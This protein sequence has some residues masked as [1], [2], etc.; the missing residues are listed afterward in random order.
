MRVQGHKG[1][2][3]YKGTRDARVARAQ[4]CEG[5]KSASHLVNFHCLIIVITRALAQQ[6]RGKQFEPR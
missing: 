2:E 1:C 3:G 4:G 5:R 6:I